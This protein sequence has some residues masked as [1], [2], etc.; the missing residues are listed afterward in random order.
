MLSGFAIRH[1]GQ[2]RVPLLV[3]NKFIIMLSYLLL[4]LVT[5]LFKRLIVVRFPPETQ[6]FLFLPTVTDHLLFPSLNNGYFPL[7]KTEEY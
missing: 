6:L 1:P 7:T 2:R 3:Q 5:L 4:L